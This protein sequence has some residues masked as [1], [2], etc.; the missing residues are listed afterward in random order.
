MKNIFK[1][2][3]RPFSNLG[4]VEQAQVVASTAVVVAMVTI[5]SADFFLGQQIG[6]FTFLSVITVGIIGYVSV[7]FSLKYGRQLEEQKNELIALNTIAEAV[8]H[9]VELDYVLHSALRKVMEVLEVDFGWIYLLETDELVLK[10]KRGTDFEF[11]QKGETLSDESI[12]WVRQSKVVREKLLQ[13]AHQI[14]ERAK[15]E[16]IQ[17]WASIPLKIKDQFAGVMIIASRDYEM[18]SEKKIVLMNSFG[19]QISVAL[20]NAQLFER[21]KSSE[22]RYAD[23]FENSPDMYHLVNHKGIIIRCNQTEADTLGYTKEEIIGQSL[24]KLYPPQYGLEAAKNLRRVF[25]FGEE[26]KGLEEQMVK[27]DGTVIDVSTNT[28]IVYDE[29]KRPLLIRSVVRD[30]TERKRLEQKI[31]QAQK[32]DSLGNLAGGVAHD[33][34]N[35]LSSILGSASIMKRKMRERDKWYR[36]VDMIEI[37]SRRGAALTRQLLTFARK[38]KVQVRPIDIN[39][40]IEET[41]HM[42]ERSV[43]KNIVVDVNLTKEFAVINGDEGQVQ[44]ALLNIFLNA[45]DAMPNGGTITVESK[46]VNAGEGKT[47]PYVEPFSGNHVMVSISDTGVGM[48]RSTQ[49]RIFE[50]FFTTKEQGKGTGLGLSVVYGVVDS[51]GG[52][53]HVQSELGVGANFSLFFPRLLDGENVRKKSRRETLVGGDETILVIDDEVSVSEIAKDML[54]GLGYKVLVANDGRQALEVHRKNKKGIDLVLLDLNM[55]KM[56]GKETLKKLKTLNGSVKILISTG[57]SDAVLDENFFAN[58]VDGFLQKP[59]RVEELAKKVREVIDQP[60]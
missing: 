13:S 57:Y 5:W 38:N 25:E 37:A 44:Q 60:C 1:N 35:I 24:L 33:F 40:I 31:L 2:I 18:L 50:P 6:W 3:R 21:L 59:Y 8:N 55:P 45:R 48:D 36:Y 7:Y 20:D 53:I 9:S 26:I 49:Q 30:I 10:Q 47:P 12:G 22:Q 34:N 14:N 19:N 16:G 32:I 28:S 41:V 58:Q 54:V 11:I 17:S 39:Y 15:W 23:L 27:K 42:F 56:N 29:S 43:E 46:I 4:I 52:F 51:H